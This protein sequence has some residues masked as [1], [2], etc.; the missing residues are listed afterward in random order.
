MGKLRKGKVGGFFFLLLRLE[1]EG[2]DF[3]GIC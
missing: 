1:M 3:V 2:G